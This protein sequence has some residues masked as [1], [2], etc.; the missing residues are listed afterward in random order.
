MKTFS[1]LFIAVFVVGCAISIGG[2]SHT[3]G[4]TIC[5]PHSLFLGGG[6]PAG[7]RL[8]HSTT[9]A[10]GESELCCEN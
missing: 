8:Y 10:Y 3:S 6:C 7:E 5:V 2:T 9:Y 1:L 4:Q